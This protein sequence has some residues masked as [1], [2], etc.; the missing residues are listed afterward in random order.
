MAKHVACKLWQKKQK[1]S[2]GERVCTRVY[3]YLVVV[4]VFMGILIY[5]VFSL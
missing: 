4:D 5:L 3:V 2:A 1:H